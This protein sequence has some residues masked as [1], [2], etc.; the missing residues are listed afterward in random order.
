VINFMPAIKSNQLSF[1]ASRGDLSFITSIRDRN[2]EIIDNLQ[3]QK[4]ETLLK[5]RDAKKVIEQYQYL[6][7]N[8]PNSGIAIDIILRAKQNMDEM[9]QFKNILWNKLREINLSILAEEEKNY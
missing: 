3:K 2:V 7:D 5:Y 6:L 8:Y 9:R 1:K 4:I